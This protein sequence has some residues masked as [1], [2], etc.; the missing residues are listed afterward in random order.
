MEQLNMLS[1]DRNI[2]IND[3]NNVSNVLVD[4][5]NVLPKKELGNGQNQNFVLED[6]EKYLTKLLTQNVLK[7]REER[8]AVT[9]FLYKIHARREEIAILTGELDIEEIKNTSGN[10]G[11]RMAMSENEPFGISVSKR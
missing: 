1:K 2:A 9:K 8:A 10:L 11:K 3:F 4:L 7:T 6:F 5:M